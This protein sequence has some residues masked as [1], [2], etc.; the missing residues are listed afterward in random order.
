MLFQAEFT[1]LKQAIK[2]TGNFKYWK[3]EKIASFEI[4]S[5]KKDSIF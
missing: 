2:P 1:D 3:L 5:V 4:D